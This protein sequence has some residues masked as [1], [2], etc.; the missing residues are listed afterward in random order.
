MILIILYVASLCSA[1]TRH[2]KYLAFVIGKTFF[3]IFFY[4]K[5][6]SN[7]LCWS[8]EIWSLSILRDWCLLN[9][10]LWWTARHTKLLHRI[11]KKHYLFICAVFLWL[12]NVLRLHDLA[13]RWI[14]NIL[15]SL[16]MQILLINNVWQIV[17]DNNSA[18]LIPR[19]NII[20]YKAF[21]SFLLLL[22]HLLFFSKE[23]NTLFFLNHCGMV[24]IEFTN[25]LVTLF[26]FKLLSKNAP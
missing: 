12:K 26:S 3:H 2:F 17:T 8:T 11:K 24:L 10:I 14:W 21:K 18:W 4:E 19:H 5:K 20:Y 13:F 23:F 25:K 15:W 1:A 6:G 9:F 16:L 7:I 22:N